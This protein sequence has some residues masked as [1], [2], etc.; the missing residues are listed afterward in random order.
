MD[1]IR[2]RIPTGR[3]QPVGYVYKH[4]QGFLNLGGPRTNPASGQSGTQTWN[5]WIESDAPT[6]WA[7]CL[8]ESYHWKTWQELWK[9]IQYAHKVSQ[10]FL[11]GVPRHLLKSVH[12]SRIWSLE[13]D[14]FFFFNVL[15]CDWLFCLSAL[16]LSTPYSF[17]SFAR[18]CL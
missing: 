10:L 15:S 1:I 18:D 13:C 12:F 9:V 16:T 2:L 5:H 6:T 4:G 11:T 14:V 7:C 17:S 8:L 3:R